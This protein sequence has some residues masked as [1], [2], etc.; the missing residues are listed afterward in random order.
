MHYYHAFFPGWM[1]NLLCFYLLCARAV[2][3]SFHF[4]WKVCTFWYPSSVLIILTLKSQRIEFQFS[5]IKNLKKIH[6]CRTKAHRCGQTIELYLIFENWLL[7]SFYQEGEENGSGWKNWNWMENQSW[8]KLVFLASI[9]NE[10]PQCARQCSV[11]CAIGGSINDD[12]YLSMNSCWVNYLICIVDYIGCTRDKQMK[13]NGVLLSL[14]F[15][16]DLKTICSMT[17]SM[18][19][20]Y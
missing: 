13:I 2:L 18:K 17:T 15:T 8:V 6:R 10:T 14:Q 12:P 3:F 11:H 9:G 19:V 7:R 5:W 20:L 4:S 16:V 1:E